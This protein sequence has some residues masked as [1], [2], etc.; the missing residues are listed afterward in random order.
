M[1]STVLAKWTA[2]TVSADTG[3]QTYQPG[4]LYV[5]LGITSSSANAAAINPVGAGA[6]WARKSLGNR[7]AVWVGTAPTTGGVITWGGTA[8]Y[9]LWLLRG[10]SPDANVFEHFGPGG[11]QAIVE[12]P[13]VD[14]GPTQAILALTR[15]ADNLS[16]T[17][18]LGV[19]TSQSS[20]ALTRCQWATPDATSPH[21]NVANFTGA[22]GNERV[23]LQVVVGSDPPPSP[24]TDLAVVVASPTSLSLTWAAPTG[25]PAPTGY[26]MSVDGGSWVPLGNVLAYTLTPLSPSTTYDIAV[27]AV[28]DTRTS[29]PATVEGTTLAPPPADP[30]YWTNRLADTLGL[31]DVQPVVEVRRWAGG[32]W[33]LD[34]DL[35]H[36]LAGYSVTYGRPGATGPADPIKATLTLATRLAPTTPEAATRLQVALCEPVATALGLTPDEA[37]RFT[38]EVTDPAVNHANR[39]TTLVCAGR[40]GR[41]NRTPVDGSAWPVEDDGARVE[42]IVA[43]TGLGMAV[44][45][46]PGTV[47]LAAPTRT[48]PGAK[49]LDLV[50]NSAGGQVVE[51][52]HGVIDWHDANRRRGVNPALTLTASEVFRSITWAQR[53][54]EVVNAATIKTAS[55]ATVE[56]V[57]AYSA[58]SETG[59]GPYPASVDTALV[60]EE[61]AY[62]LGTLLVGRRSRPA[63]S[64]PD[65]IVDLLRT[66]PLDDLPPLLR[67][68]HG[69]RLLLDGLPAACPVPPKVFVEGW[70]ET[71]TPRA[72]RLTVGVSDPMLSGVSPRYIDVP[73]TEAYR[74]ADVDPTMT[75][76][77]VARTEDP[78]E[79]L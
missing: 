53:V 40:L 73:A 63:W 47:N 29:T 76:F 38:G 22:G 58:S 52:P 77:G 44:T 25:G 67:L 51:Q 36:A 26:E 37:V 33:V 35:S 56:V 45:A 74:Y 3:V 13:I 2:Q 79:L 64:L 18:T 54:G 41:A 6:T 4:D 15:R 78:A 69:N 59:Y 31:Y 1:S 49:L 27:R 72:W 19:W 68:R 75:Y 5:L 43:A 55:G 57:D 42:R 39:L 16:H 65:V 34:A 28:V 12:G 17:G 50:I 60:D 61:D 32:S 23:F 8:S 24:P 11:S 48:E 62:A 30:R 10:V 9:G 70:T 71:A 66:V 46:D 14:V 21:R 7:S 20:G